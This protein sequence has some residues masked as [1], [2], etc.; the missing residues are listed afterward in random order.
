MADQGATDQGDFGYGQQ[1]PNDTTND[2]NATAFLVRQMISRLDTMKLVKVLAVT[3]GEGD[4]DVKK[5]GTVDVQPLVSQIDGN[6][7]ATPHGT[8]YGIPWTRAQGGKNAV[9]V[10]PEVGDIGYVVISDR[11]ISSVKE[12]QQVGPA[13]TRRQYNLA[14]GV[15]AGGAL[16]VA[17]EQYL[18]FTEKG[19]RIVSKDGGQITADKDVGITVKPGGSMPIILDGNVVVK[20]NLQLA[21]SIVA[22]D[23]GLYAGA[24]HTSGTITADTDVVGGGKSVKNHTH[25][26]DRPTGPS[27]PAQTAAPT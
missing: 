6:G 1:D 4:G 5:A 25:L 18:I 9:I 24:I 12:S 17:P 13:P 14:D 20:G 16:N 10:D 7:N 26:Y 22:E 11:D 21:G 8:V 15:Y 19:F 23:G 27:T 3:P 2:F